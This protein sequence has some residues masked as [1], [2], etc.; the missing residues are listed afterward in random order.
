MST[1]PSQRLAGASIKV[2]PLFA[3]IL[4]AADIQVNGSRPWDM[5]VHHP[6]TFARI[7]AHRSLGPRR[8]VYGWLVGLRCAGSVFLPVADARCEPNG[9]H[10]PCAAVAMGGCRR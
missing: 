2:P 9:P 8:G 3:R 7:A 5:Q 1:I 4:A 6:D 10:F